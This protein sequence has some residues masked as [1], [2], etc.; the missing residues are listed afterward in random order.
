MSAAITDPSVLL[1]KPDVQLKEKELKETSWSHQSAEEALRDLM[2]EGGCRTRGELRPEQV[3]ALWIVT[4]SAIGAVGLGLDLGMKCFVPPLAAA[5]FRAPSDHRAL[6]CALCFAALLLGAELF[7][8]RSTPIDGAP[9]L[10]RYLCLA[11]PNPSQWTIHNVFSNAPRLAGDMG[12][13]VAGTERVIFKEASKLHGPSLSW[14][15]VP[16]LPSTLALLSGGGFRNCSKVTLVAPDGTEHTVP[17]L[18]ASAAALKFK[19]PDAPGSRPH[20]KLS[21]ASMR[22]LALPAY[23]VCTILPFAPCLQ[24]LST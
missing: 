8:H 13:T 17:A 22:S 18:D 15:S 16:L 9:T 20:C 12:L 7:L 21:P 5:I 10:C 4:A 23:S 3:T 11:Y 1:S 2:A 14:A 24:E 19:M 6:I